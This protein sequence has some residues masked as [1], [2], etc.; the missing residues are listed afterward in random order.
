[1]KKVLAAS[2]FCVFLCACGAP[3]K[4]VLR[5]SLQPDGVLSGVDVLARSGFKP[6]AGKR[7]GLI[8]NPTGKDRQGRSTAQLFAEART[9]ELAALFSPEHGITGTREDENI[10]SSTILLGG[11]Q[12]PV[13]SLYAGGIVGM[14]PKQEDLDAL[15]VLVFDIQDIGSRFYTYVATMAMGMEEA[16]KAG[17]PFMVLDRPNPINGVDVEGPILDD[18]SLRKVTPTAYFAV[19]VRHGMTPGELASMHHAEL[20]RGSLTVVALAGW[21]REMWY[22]ETGLPWT[23]PSPNMP[24]L[25]AAAL[26]PGVG[27]FE[28]SNVA[29]GRGTPAPFRWIGAPWMDGTAVAAD[30]SAA[31]LDGV[32]FAPESHTPTKS[33]YK[34]VKCGGVRMKV[35][36]R[37]RLRPLAVFRKLEESLRKHHP[38]KI[39]WR[40]P[41]V[42]RMVG[43]DE[44]HRIIERGGDRE[45]IQALFDEGAERFRESRKEFL[46]Y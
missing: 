5:P 36:D 20:K 34:D 30:M 9:F 18:L 26:Y 11:R 41:E 31:L 28:A 7:V 38:D 4:Q 37:A 19:P 33:I 39:V 23:P 8:T 14:R 43:T 2:L 44:F 42:K 25:E 16:A 46:L 12:I 1:M 15:D 6:L 3:S 35:T 17:I 10:S 21:R 24:D 13:H 40:W 22:D 45:K 29:V 27:I 32:E